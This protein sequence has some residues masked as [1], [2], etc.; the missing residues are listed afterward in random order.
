MIYDRVYKAPLCLL[1]DKFEIL[2][3]FNFILR[4]AVAS[5]SDCFLNVMKVAY[6][7]LWLINNH[8]DVS[9]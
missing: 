8:V 5:G 3:I 2:K 6:V 4:L 7:T 1:L 9:L